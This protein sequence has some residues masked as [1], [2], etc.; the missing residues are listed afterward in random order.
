M[1]RGKLSTTGFFMMLTMISY[2]TP[3]KYDLQEA[4]I[5]FALKQY[6]ALDK[7]DILEFQRYGRVR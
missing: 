3:Q 5:K 1:L 4:Q 7:F 2:A 6:S